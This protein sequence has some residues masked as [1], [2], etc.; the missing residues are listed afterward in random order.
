MSR[1]AKIIIGVIVVLL[2]LCMCCCLAG[3]LTGPMMMGS[4]MEQ[5]ASATEDPQEVAQMA[6]NI[7]DYQL[8]PGYSE[9]YGMGFMGFDMVVLGTE[10]LTEQAIMLMQVPEMLGLTPEDMIRTMEQSLQSQTGQENVS[11][12]VVDTI[13]T[14]IRDQN[15]TLT[16]M[17]GSDSNGYAIKQ[18]TG[19]FRG[20][21]GAAMLMIVGP[22]QSWNQE[23]VDAFISSLH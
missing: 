5:V 13:E 10:N 17:E 19:V 16:V 20:N 2:G 8:P 21:N 23:T 11:M 1:S 3:S 18:V 14:T 22:Q 12:Y 6:G 7:V 15:V 4:I 9:Q